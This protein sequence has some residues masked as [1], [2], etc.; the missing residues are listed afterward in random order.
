MEETL[1]V[2]SKVFNINDICGIIPHRYPFLLID[3][4]I[5]T[6][7]MKKGIGYKCVSGNEDCIQ[8]HFPG[9]PVMPNVLIVEAMA[10][11]A[12]VIILSLPQFKD[13]MAYFMTINAVKFIKQ[14]FPGDVLE[15]KIEA[16][17]IKTKYGKIR[18]EAYINNTLA[19][20]AEFTF[21]MAE[22]EAVK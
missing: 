15:L 11:T 22:K 12:A 17:S 13:K 3:K 2:G 8:G 5:I 10:Q 19:A 9:K 7:A 16:Q 14:A 21:V 6:E 4:V 20:E 1:P 18:G